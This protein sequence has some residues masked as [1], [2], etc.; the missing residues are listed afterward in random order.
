VTDTA[1]PIVTPEAVVLDF[2][3][4]GVGSR[5]VAKLLDV[6]VQAGAIL[7]V[8]LVLAAG[9]AAAGAEEAA[10]V[11]LIVASFL[12]LIGYPVIIEWLWNGRTLG[13]AAMGI[14]AVTRE[15]A[16]IRFRHAALRGIIGLVEVYAFGFIA[17]LTAGLSRHDQRVGDF[18]AGT[19]VIRERTAVNHAVALSF[20][21]PAGYE[22]YADSIDTAA[23]DQQQ[24]QLIRSFL[25]RV[26]QLSPEARAA[27]AFRLANPIAVELDHDP[28]PGVGPELFLVCVATAYQKRHGGP[29]ASQWATPGWGAQPGWSPQGGWSGGQGGWTAQPGWGPPTAGGYGWGPA[30]QPP[31]AAGPAAGPGAGQAPTAPPPGWTVA[32]AAPPT[33][34]PAAAPAPRADHGGVGPGGF[35]PPA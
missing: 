32:P 14:R 34:T 8:S 20:F 12:I 30:G 19:I 28:P 7:A 9:F 15:G 25:T 24:Y 4:A 35:D 23:L 21:V 18:A 31:Y 3:T 27:M 11:L 13:K 10:T 6:L 29:S 16:P 1:S 17:V 22:S 26:L 2:E 33:A 5:S